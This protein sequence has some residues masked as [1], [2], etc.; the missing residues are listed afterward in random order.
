MQL[1]LAENNPYSYMSEG[2]PYAYMSQGNPYAYMSQGNP[3][4]YMSE[5]ITEEQLLEYYVP[6][7][8]KDG[9]VQMIREDYFD[10]LPNDQWQQAMSEGEAVVYHLNQMG[11]SEGPLLSFFWSKAAKARRQA[12]RDLRN[13]KKEAK[14]AKKEAKAA[15]IT[16]R[17]QAATTR[18]EQGTSTVGGILEKVGGVVGQVFG[19]SPAGAAAAGAEA[20]EEKQWYQNPMT[21][22]LIGG[23][24][25]AAVLVI[26][27]LNKNRKRRR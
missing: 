8:D 2:N 7:I 21:W 6:V 25:L 10:A 13:R 17:G 4:A 24:T 16:A 22:V 20:T 23:G 12:R 19:G 3:Y 5:G 15:A 1:E 14:I 26:R 11:L 27:S 18:A 9:N